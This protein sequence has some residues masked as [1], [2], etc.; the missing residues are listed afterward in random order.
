MPIPI[1]SCERSMTYKAA[2]QVQE[3]RLGGRLSDR[4]ARDGK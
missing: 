1:I 4:A 2:H 3:E